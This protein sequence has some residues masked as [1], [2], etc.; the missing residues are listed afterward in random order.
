MQFAGDLVGVL[1]GDL[2]A[3]F[4]WE[5]AHIKPRM[6]PAEPHALVG[7]VPFLFS[8]QCHIKVMVIFPVQCCKHNIN[9]LDIHPEPTRKNS[10][11]Q[12]KAA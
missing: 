3:K 9:C 8:E 1:V 12:S 10:I 2:V 6:P 4:A 5:F 11:V 7:I